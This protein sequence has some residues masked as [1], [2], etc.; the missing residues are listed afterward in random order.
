MVTSQLAVESQ[1]S[2]DV[3][4]SANF[5]QDIREVELAVTDRSPADHDDVTVIPAARLVQKGTI[6]ASQPAFRTA[7]RRVFFLNSEVMGPMQAGAKERP[8]AT[9][10]N[11][12]GL[13]IVPRAK[14]SGTEAQSVDRASAYITLS[15]MTGSR[16]GR[17]SSRSLPLMPQFPQI[18][19]PQT[20]KIGDKEYWLHLRFKR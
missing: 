16:W 8:R 15:R 18:D 13:T 5:T 12:V 3:G 11:G 2:I 6:A 19:Q 9:A 17:I 7:D 4:S 10:G 20:L 14:F 1:M